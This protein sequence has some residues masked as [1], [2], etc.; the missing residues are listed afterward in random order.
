MKKL[1]S[2]ITITLTLS[3]TNAQVKTVFWRVDNLTQIDGNAVTIS[4]SPKVIQTELGPAVE[5]DG[6]KDGLLVNDNPMNGATEFTVEIIL[7]PYSG[8][9][10]EQRYLHFQQDDNNR[11]LAELRNN[12]NLNWSLDTFIKSGTSNQTLLDYSLVHSLDNWVHV[13]LV[14]KNGV[15]TD[16]VNGVQELVGSVAYQVVNS[17]QTSLGVRMN[18]VAWFKGAIHSLKVTHQALS[19]ANFM[20]TTDFL[21]LKN[22]EKKQSIFQISPNPIVSS[23]QLKYQVEE[24]SNVSI[25]LFSTQGKEIANLFDGYKNAGDYELEINRANL[26]AGVYLVIL[27][28]GN[29]KET[30]KLIINP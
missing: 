26:E 30:Q 7:K 18:Q 20:K 22:L 8:G 13:A 2:L 9:A 25:K 5:F 16:Y 28:C 3:T 24:S 11:I 10:V 6:V 19:P 15:M 4:G 27:H 14:Y 21:G 23:A 1:L 29:K 17:G 12:N